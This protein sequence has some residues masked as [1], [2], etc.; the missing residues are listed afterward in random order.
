MRHSLTSFILLLCVSCGIEVGNPNGKPVQGPTP[1]SDD[2]LALAQ[3][4]ADQYDEAIS[5]HTDNDDAS[6]TELAL[7][8]AA[9]CTKNADGSLS[10]N[11]TRD[12][13]VVTQLPRTAPIRKVETKGTITTA[14]AFTSS[15]PRL[16]CNDAGTAPTLAMAVL[17]DVDAKST[18]TRDLTRTVTDLVSGQVTSTEPIHADAS[19]TLHRRFVDLQDKAL[20]IGKTFSFTSAIKRG[21]AAAKTTQTTT[22]FTVEV[23]RTRTELQ[24]YRI[25]SGVVSSELADGRTMTQTY[26]DLDLSVKGSCHPVFGSIAAQVF[27]A[28]D[29]VNPAYAFTIVFTPGDAQVVF[30]DGSTQDFPASDCAL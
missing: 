18:I 27:N 19:R 13:D 14:T 11:V 7:A 21:D 2:Q 8:N 17:K 25:V 24:A 6:E 4:A 22:P 20:T 29:K 16:D 10:V 23:V 12:R 5:A 3:Y 26:S 30:A 28:D 9:T 15:S 1:S